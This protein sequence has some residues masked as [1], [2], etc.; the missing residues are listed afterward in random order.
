MVK[1]EEDHM[2]VQTMKLKIKFS[3]DLTVSIIQ[4]LNSIPDF[5]IKLKRL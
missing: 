2:V 4:A 3:S 5:T 1:Q